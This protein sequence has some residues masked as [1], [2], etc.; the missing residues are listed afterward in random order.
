MRRAGELQSALTDKSFEADTLREAAV[1]AQHKER[2]SSARAKHLEEE[3]AQCVRFLVRCA[4]ARP[5]KSYP[6]TSDLTRNR[7]HARIKALEHTEQSQEARILALTSDVEALSQQV[8]AAERE[9][10]PLRDELARRP[11]IDILRTLDVQNLLQRN[12]QA[13][14]AMQGLLEWQSRQQRQ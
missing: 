2:E 1:S 6:L 12:S 14:Q 5:P 8:A 9:I 10:L 4:P 7:S 13:A 3:M 11:P